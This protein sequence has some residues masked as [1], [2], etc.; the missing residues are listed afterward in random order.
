MNDNA[1]ATIGGASRSALGGLAQRLVQDGLVAEAPMQD[2][3]VKSAMYGP[4]A[5]EGA[6]VIA[7]PQFMY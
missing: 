5:R 2:A 3:I 6:A 7:F 1:V 4:T